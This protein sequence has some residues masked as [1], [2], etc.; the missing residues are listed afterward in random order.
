MAEKEEVRYYSDNKIE[1]NGKIYNVT[2]TFPLPEDESET[3][4]DKMKRLINRDRA[5]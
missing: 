5:E 2:F 1:I 4:Y 3:A